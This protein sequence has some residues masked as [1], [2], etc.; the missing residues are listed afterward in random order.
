MA[1]VWESILNDLPPTEQVGIHGA[2]RCKTCGKEQIKEPEHAWG[3]ITGYIWFPLAGRCK[4]KTK[5]EK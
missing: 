1:H 4:P 2:R 3:R 5:K